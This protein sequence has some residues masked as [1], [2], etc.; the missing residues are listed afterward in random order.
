MSLCRRSFLKAASV[1][2]GTALVPSAIS[3]GDTAEETSTGPQDEGAA[4]YTI[5]IA[6][7]PVEIAPE[8]IISTTALDPR[9]RH[10]R[11]P[12]TG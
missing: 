7:T 1:T 3:H 5:R 8:K 12:A 9:G 11:R 2:A 10:W 6:P 4:D